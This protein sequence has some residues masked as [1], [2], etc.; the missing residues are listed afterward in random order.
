MAAGPPLPMSRSRSVPVV[1]KGSSGEWED[2]I[3]GENTG[4]RD[5][6]VVVGA[7]DHASFASDAR[8]S[9]LGDLPSGLAISELPSEEVPEE[10]RGGVQG[11]D[12]NKRET[13]GSHYYPEGGWGWVVA[14]MALMVQIVAHGLHQAGGVMLLHTLAKFPES[15]LLAAKATQNLC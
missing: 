10:G 7:S 12:P 2:D 13:I 6:G 14:V 3:E 9:L 15:S 11:E 8:S 1:D 5:S 4:G